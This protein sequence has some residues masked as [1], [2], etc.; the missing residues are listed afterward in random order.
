MI[1][2]YVDE[3]VSWPCAPISAALLSGRI[4]GYDIGAYVK[5]F[6]PDYQPSPI[7]STSTSA[8]A[9]TSTI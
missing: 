5:W 7:F 2:P 1:E 6:G 8:P 3:E 9:I 4:V